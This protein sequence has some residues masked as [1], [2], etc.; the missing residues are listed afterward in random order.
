MAI[1]TDRQ[2]QVREPF[3]NVNATD[4]TRL[5]GLALSGPRRPVD[6]AID[7]LVQ[8]EGPAWLTSV[9]ARLAPQASGL[10]LN[11]VALEDL[12]AMKET[13]KKAL[14]SAVD[15]EDR[16]AAVLVYF[17]AVGAALA[18]HGVQIAS[19]PREDIEDAISDLA[20]VV[21]GPWARML[22]RGLETT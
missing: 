5:L 12:R 9:L 2:S 21:P 1:E 20:A 16:A 4:A 15:P 7:Q 18:Q 22:C 6:D 14:V 13:G 8:L 17:L 10:P 19:R 3:A 11:E